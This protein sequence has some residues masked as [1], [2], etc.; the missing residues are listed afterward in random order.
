[1]EV[2][3]TQGNSVADTSARF[4]EAK[5]ITEAK[6]CISCE[7]IRVDRYEKF[8]FRCKLYDV[9]VRINNVCDNWKKRKE[10]K[11]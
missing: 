5:M 1:M 10:S 3:R 9:R 11:K 7:N 8:H 6:C 2:G 4:S